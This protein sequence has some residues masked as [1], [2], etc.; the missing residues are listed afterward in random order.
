MKQLNFKIK[1]KKLYSALLAIAFTFMQFIPLNA[2]NADQ[3]ES[4]IH[5][6][7]YECYAKNSDASLFADENGHFILKNEKSG[8]I[9]SSIPS[10]YS[11]DKVSAGLTKTDIR[12]ELIIEYFFRSDENKNV[13]SQKSNSYVMAESNSGIEVS[14]IT[15]G[16]KVLYRMEEIEMEI[17]VIYTLSGSELKASVDLKTFKEGDLCYLISLNLLPY[18]GAADQN[19]GGSMFIPDGSGAISEFNKNVLSVN[20][21]EKVIYGDDTVYEQ[22]SGLTNEKNISIPVFGLFHDDSNGLMGTV[23]SGDGSAAICAQTVGPGINYNAISSKLIYRLFFK[24]E[25]F[26]STGTSNTIYTVSHT[27]FGVDKYTVRYTLLSGNDANY[28]GIAAYY[29]KELAKN[30]NLKKTEHQLGLALRAYGCY[31]EKK[32]FLGFTYYKKQSLTNFEQMTSILK[33]LKDSGC[34]NISVQYVGWNGNG[35]I[36]RLLPQKAN[37]LSVLGGK[38]GFNKLVDYISDNDIELYPNFDMLR[39]KKG[40]NGVSLKKSTAKVSSG[41]SVKLY[42]YSLATGEKSKDIPVDYL[43]NLKLLPKF[44]DNLVSFYSKLNVNTLSLSTLGSY[45]Y[46]DLRKS[47][48]TYRPENEIA[49]TQTLKSVNDKGFSVSVDNA[50]AY[51]FPYVSKVFEAP[52]SSSGYDFFTYDVPFYQ[53]VLSGYISYTTESMIQSVDYNKMFLK[54]LETGSDLLFETIFEDSSILRETELS[55][56][57]SSSYEL[58]SNK[59]KQSY[60]DINAFNNAVKGNSI[61][62]HERIADDVYCTT[63][64]NGIKVYVNYNNSDFKSDDIS[65]PNL[66][67]LI[68]GA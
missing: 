67:Y 48:G 33:D 15:D 66:G 52:S 12:S 47:G 30:Y 54:A 65:I 42:H 5:L 68:K 22:D 10:N 27:D 38:K 2:E 20:K 11:E 4:N 46:S 64:E 7:G 58:W 29:R 31:E 3:S 8:K 9:W 39:F 35:A 24:E 60:E 34:G 6:N 55:N 26:Y 28:N 56:L 44:T 17:P 32:S 53:M 37:P 59:A 62:N 41:D 57:Y 43:L 36:N 19:T 16:F 13:T 14:K 61:I 23:I 50:N 25:S 21:Y 18:F 49:V 63:Y 1:R 40:G 51:V 45:L